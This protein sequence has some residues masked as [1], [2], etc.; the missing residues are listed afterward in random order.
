MNKSLIKPSVLFIGG[1]GVGKTSLIEQLWPQAIKEEVIKDVIDYSVF[2][3]V[4]DSIV[5][6]NDANT[7]TQYD[8]SDE[9]PG[10]GRMDYR[11]TELPSILY[12]LQ[13]QWLSS[14]R[15]MQEISSADTIVIVMPASSFG[16]K[17]ELSFVKTLI[18][19]KLL[20]LQH[21]VICL[22]KA[23]YLFFDAESGSLVLDGMTR[24]LHLQSSLYIHLKHCMSDEL[25]DA[26]SVVL[27]STP[28]GW[29]FDTMR[30]KIWEGII[31]RQNK[32]IYDGNIPTVVIAGKRGSGKSST[33]NELWGL[34]LPT[35]KAVACTKY[36]MVIP[37]AGKLNGIE[38]KFNLVDLPGIA[39]SLDADM[40]YTSYYEKYIKRA[41]LLICLSQADT[42]AYKQDE[43]FYTNLIEQGILTKDTNIILGINQIDLLF[44]SET[45][46]D[47]IDLD[48]ITYDDALIQEKISDYYDNVY[49]KIFKDFPNVTKDN[50]CV[51]SALK[52]WNLEFLLTNIINKLK[53]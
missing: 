37:I 52:R 50:V 10:R 46:P 47:G 29:N 41:S 42:R 19:K 23:D 30:E 1:L 14:T 22:N 53:N 11:V 38:Y 3:N 2:E 18:E 21:L 8:V 43:L 48:T 44:K 9:V 45:N 15:V 35:N 5:S 28:I 20:S 6:V 33:L 39:E 32:C 12:S 31:A 7:L 4:A 49:S 16:Y 40:Q 36:P 13:E 25:F 24:M 17:Q 27:L 26:D 34:D 51:L